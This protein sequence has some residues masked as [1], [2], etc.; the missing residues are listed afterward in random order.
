M[1]NPKPQRRTAKKRTQREKSRA[2]RKKTRS[3]KKRTAAKPATPRILGISAIAARL[4]LT[5]RRIQQ[6][7]AEGMPRIS[8]GKYDLDQALDWYIARL[9]RQLAGET[10]EDGETTYNK[11]RSRDRAAAADLKELKIAQQRRELVAVSDV[12]KELTD[13]VITVKASV[14]AVPPRLAPKLVGLEALAVQ[15]ALE[16]ELKQALTKLSQ[17]ENPAVAHKA[18][19]SMHKAPEPAP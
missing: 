8:R 3:E 13:L 5:P 6:L 2:P 10:D 14:L 17:H 19:P 4:K 11:E 16:E 15:G 1:P 7:V 18:R 12:E 9:E